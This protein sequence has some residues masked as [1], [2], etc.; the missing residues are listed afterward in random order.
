MFLA[1]LN[2]F[3]EDIHSIITTKAAEEA[4]VSIVNLL[5]LLNCYSKLV[6]LTLS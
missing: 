6:C 1:P 4:V 2:S 5:A 3:V